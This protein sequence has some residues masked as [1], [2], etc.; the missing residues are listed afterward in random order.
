MKATDTFH[1][2]DYGHNCAQAVAYRWREK[3]DD[4]NIVEQMALCG[5]GRAPEGICG[6]LYAAMQACPA[7]ADSIKEKFAQQCGATTCR[8]LKTVC[9][10][11]CTQCVDV[12]DSLVE[13]A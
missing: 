6:A 4:P 2:P 5:G 11:P 7:Q 12:A 10:T 9:R 8:M 3:Y 1:H 13:Q